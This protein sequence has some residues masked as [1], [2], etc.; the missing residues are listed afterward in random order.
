MSKDSHRHP[1]TLGVDVPDL[2]NAIRSEI[3]IANESGRYPPKRRRATLCRVLVAGGAF[4]GYVELSLDVWRR[5][6]GR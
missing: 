1:T 4:A 5:L 2:Q 6:H 3:Q